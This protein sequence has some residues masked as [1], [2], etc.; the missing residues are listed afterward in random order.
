MA[1]LVMPI[2]FLF[3]YFEQLQEDAYGKSTLSTSDVL[4]RIVC[5]SDGKLFDKLQIK[6][7]LFYLSKFYEFLDTVFL[8]VTMRKVIP[9]HWIHHILTCY[10][11]WLGMEAKHENNAQIE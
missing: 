1:S 9:F 10:I 4:N 2:G 5:D 8:C 3:P 6:S 7:Y 11:S